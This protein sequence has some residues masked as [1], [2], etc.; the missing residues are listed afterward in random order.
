MQARRFT[1]F[2]LAIILFGLNLQSCSTVQQMI[3]GTP[4]FTST[5]TLTTTP[6][7]T[8]TPTSTLTPTET[9]SPTVTPNL[10]ATQQYEAFFPVVQQY[11]DLGYIPTLD[12][13]FYVL[14]DYSDA[15]AKKGYYSWGTMGKKVRNLIM[16]SHLTMLTANKASAE[17]A[18]GIVFRVTGD[19]ANVVFVGQNGVAFYGTNNQTF[20]SSRYGISSNPAEVDLVLL[21][22]EQ[23]IRLFID[24]EKALVYDTF[25]DT[26]VGD[27]GFTV[28]SGSNDDFGSRCTFTNNGL[29]VIR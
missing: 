1:L 24:G 16:K 13:D 23:N 6:T 14:D 25:L 22:N 27:V 26:Y 20:H 5:A 12:G 9:P 2:Y 29:W 10:L 8:A 11:F 15:L 18:C 19:Y 17:T 3:Q 4:T 28:L 21:V 7:L